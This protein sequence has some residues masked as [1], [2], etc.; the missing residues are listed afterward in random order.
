MPDYLGMFVMAIHIIPKARFDALVAKSREPLITRLAEESLWFA[1]AGET[2]IGAVIFDKIDKNW[3]YVVLT[4][5]DG[6]PFRWVEGNRSI[7]SQLEATRQL[8]AAMENV[9]SLQS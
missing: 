3:S 9:A 7:D 8:H 2:V 5:P 1:T 4:N 6:G